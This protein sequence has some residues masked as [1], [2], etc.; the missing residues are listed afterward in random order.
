MRSGFT[1]FLANVWCSFPCL[2][3]GC[4]QQ[5]ARTRSGFQSKNQINEKLVPYLAGAG[6]QDAAALSD[7]EHTALAKGSTAVC[8]LSFPVSPP[9]PCD[10]FAASSPDCSALLGSWSS[11]KQFLPKLISVYVHPCTVMCWFEFSWWVSWHKEE[12]LCMTATMKVSSHSR[13]SW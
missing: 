12:G 7:A 6:R 2:T 13:T 1:V 8:Q 10:L 5:A 3:K 11:E 9:S 4:C